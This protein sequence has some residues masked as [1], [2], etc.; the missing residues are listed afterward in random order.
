[1]LAWCLERGPVGVV[2]DG[3]R[4]MQAAKAQAL[5][6]A[7]LG[8]QVIL[9]DELGGRDSWKPS[10]V[11]MIE[12]CRRMEVDPADAVYVGDNPAKDFIAAYEAGMKAIRYRAEHQLHHGAEPSPGAEPDAQISDLGQLRQV[13]KIGSG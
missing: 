9:S 4:V 6:L 5:G 7:E 2:T 3:P 12:A 11:G 8:I 1:M 10:P 13:L